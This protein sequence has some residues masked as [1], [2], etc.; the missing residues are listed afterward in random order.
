MF[1][2]LREFAGLEG[3]YL[4]KRLYAKY[5]V[6]YRTAG[7]AGFFSNYMWVLGHVIMARRLGYI[8][9]VDMERYLTLYSEEEPIDGIRNAWNYYFENVGEITLEQAYESGSYV[10]GRDMPLHKY[11]EKFCTGTYRFPT[12]KAVSYYAPII[13]QHIRIKKELRQDFAA[14]WSKQV[15]E[16]VGEQG[17]VLGVHVR[18]TDMKNNLGHPM[19]A[20]VRTY[21]RYVHETLEKDSRITKIFLATDE[22]DV[23]QGFE[24]E[25]R[26]TKWTLFVNPAFRVWD[27]KEERKTG[28]HETKIENPR[29]RHKYLM[30]KEVLM[31]AWFLSRCDYL[32][33]G[34]SNITNVAILWNHNRYRQIV[35]VGAEGVSV[36][37]PMGEKKR[38]D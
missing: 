8:P 38:A 14:E 4:K 12:R 36:V 25:F 23:K 27:S 5:Y 20:D 18:G 3:Y 30:G 11:E 31:D 33:C 15:G 37:W 9:V 26:E 29:E 22:N 10:M 2:R 1:M 17:L 28:I 13:E 34:H 7:G 35:C 24:E 32:V 21:L 19:P 6:I 16:R